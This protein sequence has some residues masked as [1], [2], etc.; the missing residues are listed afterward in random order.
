MWSS[1]CDLPWNGR[2][3]N[4]QSIVTF[5]RWL[6]RESV[7]LSPIHPNAFK[8]LEFITASVTSERRC[9]SLLDTRFRRV[10]EPVVVSSSDIGRTGLLDCG[11]AVLDRTHRLAPSTEVIGPP[12]GSGSD[13]RPVQS[14]PR[15]NTR[16][17][18]LARL[19]LL[20]ADLEAPR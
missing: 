1:W 19:R 8:K 7:I 10:R 3:E 9:D 16:Y 18:A 12:I 5:E 20:G 6:C 2:Y 11:D 17:P 13:V 15:P 4:P 14:I